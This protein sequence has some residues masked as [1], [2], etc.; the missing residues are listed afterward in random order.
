MPI[1]PTTSGFLVSYSRVK[2]LVFAA[3][4]VLFAIMMIAA[5]LDVYFSLFAGTPFEDFHITRRP[6]WLWGGVAVAGGCV[7]VYIGL[8]NGLNALR[9]K[10][11]IEVTSAGVFATTLI[12]RRS[13]L[14]K[15][16]GDVRVV[17][18]TLMLHPANA[19]RQKTVPLQTFLTS[20]D[21]HELADALSKYRPEVFSQTHD[22]NI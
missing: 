15:D 2:S 6:S 7:L 11:A 13:I 8:W 5:G 21:A 9:A 16:L 17:K 20:M 10:A 14:W 1:T 3:G 4:A 19:S 22:Q 18:S 12:G